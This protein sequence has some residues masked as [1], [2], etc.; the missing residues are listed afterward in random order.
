MNRCKKIVLY[1]FLLILS[2]SVAAQ[3]RPDATE[4]R[5]LQT[6]LFEI[7]EHLVADSLEGR[8]S[9]TQGEIIARN[10][11]TAMFSEIGLDPYFENDAYYQSF[12]FTSNQN[13]SAES[14]IRIEDSVFTFPSEYSVLTYSGLTELKGNVF[15][16]GHGLKMNQVNDYANY[17]IKDIQDRIF[18]IDVAF[19]K[20]FDFI[21][22]FNYYDIVQHVINTAIDHGASGI[23]LYQSRDD[24][25]TFHR[26]AFF[27]NSKFEVPVLFD[28]GKI[29]QFVR[30]NNLRVSVEIKLV[31]ERQNRT[32]YNV[33]AKVDNNA[34]KTIVVGAHYDHLGY[35]SPIS[36][37]IG[38]PAI[39]PGADDNA[40][41]VA[42][43]LE[44]ARFVKSEG[45]SDHNY[46]F[47][48]FGAEEKGL[49][50]SKAF[51]DDTLTIMPDVLAMINIDMVGRLDTD[52]RKLNVLNTGSSAKWDSLIN[53]LF[54]PDIVLH[55]NPQGSGGSDHMSFYLRQIPVLF[56]ITGIH[57]D[58]HTPSD[59]LEKINFEGMAD[60]TIL[61]SDLIYH[62]NSVSEMP[63]M[64]PEQTEASGN[65]PSRGGNVTLG[66]VP[67]HA[68]GGKGLRID[69]VTSGRI[70]DHAGLKAGDI[71]IAIDENEVSDITSYMK[72]MSAYKTG[73]EARLK[74][75]RGSE[76]H[77][78]EVTF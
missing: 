14:Y 35:G 5:E 17:N 70:A 33:A 55:L 50:G 62:M 39:H 40:S 63:F 43:M 23:I 19:P 20:H 3:W 38:A 32:A 60:I 18:F 71:I 69:A 78:F 72:A 52:S 51:V 46:V 12:V 13:F 42:V 49:V 8:E 22:E 10:F 74:V 44:L 64:Q 73:D 34:K 36:R 26:K 6:R 68:Y 31:P 48:A 16:A 21:D 27:Q 15:F 11:I 59:V 29:N 54:N 75:I 57:Q 53:V 65:R 76:D 25:Y 61:L 9:G 24:V 45:L 77:V 37:H 28:E 41:G 7:M 66:I 2:I 56:F 58:Y 4:K 47:V 30:L 67:D 1:L